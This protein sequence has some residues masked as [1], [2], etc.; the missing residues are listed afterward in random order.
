MSRTPSHQAKE[1]LTTVFNFLGALAKKQLSFTTTHKLC[2][3][4]TNNLFYQKKQPVQG[5]LFPHHTPVVFTALALI[6]SFAPQTLFAQTALAPLTLSAQTANSEHVTYATATTGTLHRM[7]PTM[8]RVQPDTTHTVSIQ[9]AGSGKVLDILVLPG[10]FVKQG[11]PLLHYQNHALHIARLQEA[12]TRTALAA[13]LATQQEAT[14]AYT[15]ARALAGQTV[16]VGEAQKR[17]AALQQAKESVATRQAEL[18]VLKHRFDEEYTSPTEQHATQDE[19]STLIAPFA[20]T[21]TRLTTAVAAD[22]EPTVPL[23]TLSDSQHVWLV[24]DIAPQDAALLAP[25]GLQ[26][27]MLAD[28]TSPVLQTHIETIGAVADPATGLVPVLS[29]ADNSQGTLRP[30]MTLNSQLQTTQS[31]TGLLLPAEAV[32][33]LNDQSMVFVKFSGNTIR[34]TPVKVGLEDGN[35]V[36][37]LSGLQAG[38]QVVQ[39]GS[40]ALKAMILLPAMDAE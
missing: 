38:A 17:R 28:N 37:V 21:I 7:L 18:A 4:A 33:I 32:Q 5:R 10:Q 26:D 25:N 39:H 9:P 23:L 12:Q 36:V 22:V 35:T 19:T 34:P 1:S 3:G 16:S 24:S 8:S 15:R 2:L 6:T 30:G 31:Q 13:A 29:R 11:Q 14:Q 40:L 20:G 27:V